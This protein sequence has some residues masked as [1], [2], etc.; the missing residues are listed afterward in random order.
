MKSLL[1][2]LFELNKALF[3][4]KDHTFVDPTSYQ[5][6]YAEFSEDNTRN[7]NSSLNFLKVMQ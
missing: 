6:V 1:L 4:T 3:L 2:L 5:I 7:N